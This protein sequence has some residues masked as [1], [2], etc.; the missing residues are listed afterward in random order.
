MGAM[1]WMGRLERRTVVVHM[2]SGASVR[3]VVIGVYRDS[4]VLRHSTYLGPQATEI[5]GDVVI[6]RPNVAWVQTLPEGEQP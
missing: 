6:P 2:A 1:R 3:G 5:D 4:V